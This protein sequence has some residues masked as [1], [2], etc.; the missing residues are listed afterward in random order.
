MNDT[1]PP[2][3]P[4]P[5]PRPPAGARPA[6]GAKPR[7]QQPISK[8]SRFVG[9]LV[10]GFGLLAVIAVLVLAFSG[11]D[12]ASAPAVEK[13]ADATSA[14][15]ATTQPAPALLPSD[16]V[17]DLSELESRRA[18]PVTANR[19]LLFERT[20]KFDAGKMEGDWQAMIGRYTAVLQIRKDVYQ[21]ILASSDPSTPR[22][23]SSGTFIVNEDI[24]TLSPRQDW[25]PP[26]STVKGAG[27]SKLTRG[28]FPIIA[29]FDSGKM[30]WQNP[31]ASEKRVN[32]P[33]ISPIFMSESVRLASW[34][35]IK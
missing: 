9:Y 14:T 26:S 23:Y 7:R 10:L 35:K 2:Q 25:P 15:P 17:N 34:Q 6:G 18:K 12:N 31:P 19:D 11:G 1:S 24:I 27:Y 32:G 3:Q 13:S 29:R 22:Y 30:L 16:L 4:K 5:R 33:H 21:I 20:P 8:E 28:P